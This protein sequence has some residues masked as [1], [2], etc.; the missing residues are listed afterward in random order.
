QPQHLRL[1]VRPFHAF[2]L[3]RSERARILTYPTLEILCR[4]G[5]AGDV[6]ELAGLPLVAD[7][8]HGDAP[9][10][11]RLAD[12]VLGRDAGP[13]EQDLPELGRDAVD[14][15]KRLLLDTRL[16]HRDGEG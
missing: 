10:I 15:P 5:V 1:H 3:V 7:D 11:A 13:V 2:S 14:H 4:L 9:T 16:V 12:H 6:A 8:R